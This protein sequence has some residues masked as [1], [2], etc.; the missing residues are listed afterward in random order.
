MRCEESLLPVVSADYGYRITFC[1]GILLMYGLLGRLT[2]QILPFSYVI[3]H[4]TVDLQLDWIRQEEQQMDDP[5]KG[6]GRLRQ[7]NC[8]PN[9]VP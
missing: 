8:T 2:A 1:C 4:G 9:M 7:G 5:C 3:Q 6:Q